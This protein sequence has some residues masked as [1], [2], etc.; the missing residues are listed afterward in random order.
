[1]TPRQQLATAFTAAIEKSFVWVSVAR[2]PEAGRISLVCAKPN[3][4]EVARFDGS[5][6]LKIG[7][8]ALPFVPTHWMDKR[9]G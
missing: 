4:R 3:H 1:V 2:E 7:E 5:T 6:W 9:D 8:Q